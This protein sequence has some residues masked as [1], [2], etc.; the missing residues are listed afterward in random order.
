MPTYICTGNNVGRENHLG[1]GRKREIPMRGINNK[2]IFNNNAACL[3]SQG[4]L[5]KLT[6]QVAIRDANN[7]FQVRVMGHEHRSAQALG[8]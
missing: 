7:G 8:H 4:F 3:G 1:N 6:N 2:N 5:L